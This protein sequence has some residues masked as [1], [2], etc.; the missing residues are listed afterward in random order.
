MEAT[1]LN[2]WKDGLDIT[3]DVTAALRQGLSRGCGCRGPQ[4]GGQVIRREEYERLSL[5]LRRWNR[6][7]RESRS[8]RDTV[9]GAAI[10]AAVIL[11]FTFE[12]VIP[13]RAEQSAVNRFFHFLAAKDYKAAYAMFGCTD[14]KPCREY[15]LKSFTEDWGAV[16]VT[17]YDVLSGESCGSGVIV[18]V[19]AGKAGDKKIWVERKGQVL[20]WLPPNVAELG[21]CP[22]GNRIYDWCGTSNIACTGVPISKAGI[23]LDER[24]YYTERPQAGNIELSILP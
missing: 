9:G 23:T 19:D 3:A 8:R 7:T 24:A 2:Y 4:T 11:I 17:G 18:D 22:Q 13:N 15:P 21:R 14:A 16:D 1:T 6:E 20:G 5:E 12:F 10:T